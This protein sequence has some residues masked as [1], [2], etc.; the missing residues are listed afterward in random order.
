MVFN[1]TNKS[2]KIR[3][4]FLAFLLKFFKLLIFVTKSF[5]SVSRIHFTTTTCYLNKQ[6][7][8]INHFRLNGYE[9]TTFDY[10]G[11]SE[12]DGPVGSLNNWIVDA[13]DVFKTITRKPVVS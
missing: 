12:S 7:K 5:K 1:K 4:N 2:R 8:K 3:Y 10:R 9:F 13:T 11:T 6:L